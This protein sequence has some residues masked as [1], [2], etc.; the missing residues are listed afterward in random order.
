MPHPEDRSRNLHNWSLEK[1]II[2]GYHRDS[3]DRVKLTHMLNPECKGEGM[4]EEDQMTAA[5]H[6]LQQQRPPQRRP[7]D[8]RQLRQWQQHDDDGDDDVDEGRG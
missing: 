8:G 6:W 7:S 5:V 1:D 4:K 2:I 3:N